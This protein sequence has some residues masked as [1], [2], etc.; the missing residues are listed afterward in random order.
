MKYLFIAL[1]LT[2][3]SDHKPEGPVCEFYTTDGGSSW[4]VIIAKNNCVCPMQT[5]RIRP[6]HGPQKRP[7]AK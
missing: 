1:L 4:H 7:K 5:K 3:C 6:R 2:A